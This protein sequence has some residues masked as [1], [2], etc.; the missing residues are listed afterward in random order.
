MESR[1]DPGGMVLDSLQL[2]S[3]Q[4]GRFRGS[5][6][7][8]LVLRN[9]VVG[10]QLWKSMEPMWTLDRSCCHRKPQIINK[11]NRNETTQQSE[12]DLVF[13]RRRNELVPA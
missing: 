2:G 1:R 3:G 11:G 9:L 10:K 4:L 13:G 5:H 7:S 8:Q 6:P 12:K